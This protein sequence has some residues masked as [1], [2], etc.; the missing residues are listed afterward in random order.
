MNK[1]IKSGSKITEKILKAPYIHIEYWY[2]FMGWGDNYISH[3]II[4][5]LKI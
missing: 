1:Q 5:R 3:K 4:K 2:K